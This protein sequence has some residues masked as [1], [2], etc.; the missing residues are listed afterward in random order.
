MTVSHGLTL[1]LSWINLN[2]NVYRDYSTFHYKTQSKNKAIDI[3]DNM[4]PRS[5]RKLK[6]QSLHWHLIVLSLRPSLGCQWTS[7]SR[8]VNSSGLYPAFN[9]QPRYLDIW[10]LW[11]SCSLLGLPRPFEPFLWAARPCLYGSASDAPT[12]KCLIVLRECQSLSMLLLLWISYATRVTLQ[13]P[14]F[15]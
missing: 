4:A 3:V 12:I 6:T 10:I 2:L 9:L 7:F 5:E 13:W 1:N 11:T 8:F 14:N 15:F